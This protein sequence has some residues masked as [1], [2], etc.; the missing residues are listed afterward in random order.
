MTSQCREW[1]VECD[2]G[3]AASG[4]W[5]AGDYVS[6]HGCMLVEANR[7][8]PCTCLPLSSLLWSSASGLSLGGSF[9]GRSQMA[10]CKAKVKSESQ[11]CPPLRLCSCTLPLVVALEAAYWG[12]CRSSS[13]TSRRHD[14]LQLF[15]TLFI[16]CKPNHPNRILQ[17]TT[18]PLPA[19][20]EHIVSA[21]SKVDLFSSA[22]AKTD[23]QGSWFILERATLQKILGSIPI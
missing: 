13:V 17:P 3:C 8:L 5:A 4:I 12:S 10:I 22:A 1:P 15:P 7:K 11:S 21:Q 9:L 23:Y 14:I 6:H 19:H 2:G 18:G 20:R 16:P